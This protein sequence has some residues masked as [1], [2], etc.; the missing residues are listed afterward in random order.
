MA[1]KPPSIF[2]AL[3]Y[4]DAPAALDWLARAFGFQVRFVVPGENGT[5]AHAE[6]SFGNGVIMPG[7]VKPDQGW[8]SPLDL[9]AVHQVISIY[10]ADPDA[11]CARACVAGADITH[12]L[13]TADYGARGYVARDL[14]GNH[15]YF[16]NYQPGEFWDRP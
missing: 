2:P 13:T 3:F 8:V 7:S 9:P 11:H 5:I 6:L 12:A 14:E 16:G 15:W 10:V 4:R 1:D